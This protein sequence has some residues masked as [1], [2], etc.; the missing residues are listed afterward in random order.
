MWK[1]QQ[2]KMVWDMDLGLKS[3][4]TVWQAEQMLQIKHRFLEILMQWFWDW[5]MRTVLDKFSRWHWLSSRLTNIAMNNL[6]IVNLFA[7]IIENFFLIEGAF[8]HDLGTDKAG[9]EVEN[10]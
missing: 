1:Q 5:V 7:H 6:Q 10:C 8:H 4:L 3:F 2:Q 9:T